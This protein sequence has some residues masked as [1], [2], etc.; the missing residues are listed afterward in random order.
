M[1]NALRR[2]GL[3]AAA[4]CVRAF[5]KRETVRRARQA[6]FV[7]LDQGCARLDQGGHLGTDDCRQPVQHGVAAVAVQLDCLDE[8]Q[9]ARNRDLEN[10]VRRHG[11]EQREFLDCAEAG[12]GL[13]RA[14][15]LVMRRHIIAG[16]AQTPARC[17]ALKAGQ[18]VEHFV[19]EALPP[20]FAVAENVDAG[21]H[22]VRDDNPR[23][24]LEQLLDV[25][26][27]PFA[28]P[29]C[30]PAGD[31]PT[32]RRQGADTHCR[33]YRQRRN[34]NSVHA[35]NPLVRPLRRLSQRPAGRATVF[36]PPPRLLCSH[37]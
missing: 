7:D 1:N 18:P 21:I 14:G 13:D 26:I 8:G 4:D 12:R 20:Q 32:G 30:A 3:Q 36:L 27:A 10:G 33:Q 11:L 23:R 2:D 16:D 31:K 19:D 35:K 24:V 17:G 28:L 22:L 15:D 9:R 5:R 37:V 34:R 25:M 29:C 6:G